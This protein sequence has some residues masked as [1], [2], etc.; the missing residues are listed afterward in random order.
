MTTAQKYL[1]CHDFYNGLRLA[2]HLASFSF[3]KVP[4]SKYYSMYALLGQSQ[5]IQKVDLNRL[6]PVRDCQFIFLLLKS[7]RLTVPTVYT[8][9]VH[10]LIKVKI[11]WRGERGH[12]VNK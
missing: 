9:H 10:D 5:V 8:G 11:D 4:L 3:Q 6:F 7:N 2:N 12:I 1:K